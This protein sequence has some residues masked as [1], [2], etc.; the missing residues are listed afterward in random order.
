M[1]DVSFGFTEP[2][3]LD[4][5]IQVGFVVYI[6]RFNFDQGRE[7]SILSGQNL[8]PLFNQLGQQN[9]LNYIQ[10]GHGINLSASKMLRNG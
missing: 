7:A 10:N 1:R 8:I 4:K 9:L 5:P 6:R 2:Y 3:F